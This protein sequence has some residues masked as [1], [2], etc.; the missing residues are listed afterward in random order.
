MVRKSS[1]ASF[2][3]AGSR[4]YVSEKSAQVAWYN[5]INKENQHAKI[6]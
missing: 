3:A 2:G 5:G 6:I 4:A 1:N